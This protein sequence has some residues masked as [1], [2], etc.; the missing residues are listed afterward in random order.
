MLSPLR[1][2]NSIKVRLKQD[3]HW[4][5]ACRW[6]FQF[7]KGTIKTRVLVVF[8]ASDD[9]FNSIKVR[10]K[11]QELIEDSLTLE[12]FNSIKVRLK[13]K[14]WLQALPLV[15]HFNSIKV[16]LK[17]GGQINN[18]LKSIFQFHKGTIKTQPSIGLLSYTQNFNS[19]KVRLKHEYH[20]HNLYQRPFQF[21]KG[22]IKTYRY[23]Q[24]Q[25]FEPISIP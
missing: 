19:I 23:M 15:L 11:L 17:H 7:H 13:Q 3:I 5:F 8:V 10:L 24:W 20:R 16:R 14:I 9:N 22:T 4:Q 2:F 18:R 12:N 6:L 1:N 21:H 25:S